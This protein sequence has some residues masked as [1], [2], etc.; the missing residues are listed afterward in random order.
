M[1]SKSTLV[2]LTL[3]L[4]TVAVKAQIR[5][6]TNN[7]VGIGNMTNPVSLLELENNK[8]IRLNPVTGTAGILFYKSGTSTATSVQYGGKLYYDGSIDELRL[9]TV[10]N[11]TFKQALDIKRS[12][13]EIGMG[14]SPMT[15]Y[16]LYVNGK[17]MIEGQEFRFTAST[18]APYPRIIFSSMHDIYAELRDYPSTPI[19]KLGLSTHQWSEIRGVSIYANGVYLSSDARLKENI[20][21]LD[22]S[23]SKVSSLRAVKYDFKPF[24]VPT[25]EPYKSD[26][27]KINNRL[28]NRT[29]FLAQE[30]M[31]V[32]PEVV[33][34]NEEDDA[35][36]IDYAA[37]IPQL[38]G[39]MQEQQKQI[40]ELRDEVQLLKSGGIKN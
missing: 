32:M 35:Y 10:E 14:K 16:Q 34:Y 23:L 17:T 30:V 6:T 31:E 9:G 22:K 27:E 3:L 18:T 7:N 12:T 1:K 13:G 11:N 28:K 15:G 24:E 36:Y 33:G 40:Q 25:E 26:V 20:T 21:T 2:I 19:G 29:G 4:L 39:A 38:V 5:V 37:I 8:W